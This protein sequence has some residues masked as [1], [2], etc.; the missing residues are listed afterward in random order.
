MKSRQQFTWAVYDAQY[1]DDDDIF[2]YDK[3]LEQCL[4]SCSSIPK[5][6]LL[7]MEPDANALFPE[8]GA[9]AGNSIEAYLHQILPSDCQ[10]VG[11]STPGVVSTSRD[12]KYISES[13]DQQTSCACVLF[14]KM[15]G[16][17][18]HIFRVPK[19]EFMQGSHRDNIW[20][21]TGIPENEDVKCI[22]IIGFN[23]FAFH[24]MGQLVNHLADVYNK[25]N[26]DI[27]ISGA[28]ANDLV[29]PR[30]LEREEKKTGILGLV[31]SG[32]NVKAASVVLNSRVTH[33]DHA[34]REL[35]KLKSVGLSEK[36]TI[37]FMFACI[38]RGTEHYNQRN[39]ESEAFKSIF[40]N[41][42]LF[43]FFGNGE[44]GCEQLKCGKRPDG[45]HPLPNAISPELL[46]AY[47][48]VFCM[49]SFDN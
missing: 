43:G 11:F 24:A 25:K 3:E 15:N 4:S 17:N 37:A 20:K 31:F 49:I 1:Q 38:G 2:T 8:N 46:H 28:Y 21:T 9:Y 42:P 34:K 14:P 33:P 22:L 44:V 5:L 30:T 18:I 29:T 35:L 39:V 13:E 47:T 27:V 7:F 6:A 48:T 16:V 12:L 32:P 19:N 10:L 23:R 36:K 26:H 40:P 41:T 45:S